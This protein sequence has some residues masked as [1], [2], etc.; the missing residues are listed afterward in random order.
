MA[1]RPVMMALED[2]IGVVSFRERLHRFP[3]DSSVA[4][5]EQARVSV[6]GVNHGPVF[7]LLQVAFAEP[8]EARE[9]LVVPC[10]CMSGIVQFQ[11]SQS[12]HVGFR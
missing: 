9:L 5:V 2:H 3:D 12:S 8:S 10:R 4:L 1:D 11:F 7:R 6:V